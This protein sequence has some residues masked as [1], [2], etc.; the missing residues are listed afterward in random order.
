M[1]L[2]MSAMLVSA[3]LAAAGAPAAGTDPG[4]EP[5]LPTGLD[6]QDRPYPKL[7][8]ARFPGGASHGPMRWDH[9]VQGELGSCFFLSTLAEI[10]KTHPDFAAK[11]IRDVGRGAYL[12]TLYGRDGK[13]TGVAVDDRFPATVSGAPFFG[14]G[15]EPEEIRPALFEKAFAKLS[16]GYSAIDGGDATDA[17]KALTGT[18]GR[19][20]QTERLSD[21]EAWRLLTSAR[22]TARPV[23]A[24]TRELPEL[25]RLTGREDLNGVIDDHVY[26]LVEVTEKDGDR[27]V[28]LYTPLSPGD[29]GYAK[30]G[31]RFLDLRLSDFKKY[32]DTITIGTLGN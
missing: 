11:N 13:R 10:A 26:A 32:F 28:R 17:F 3:V 20:Y 1:N 12:V 27:R 21:N 15:L 29:A 30:N 2:F 9:V 14:R 24:S 4:T 31:P 18:A 5:A 25:K 23:V 19:D 6:I 16:G 7:R 8:Y 22:K